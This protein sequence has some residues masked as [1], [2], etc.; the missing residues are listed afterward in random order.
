M[1]PPVLPLPLRPQDPSALK[2]LFP[3]VSTRTDIIIIDAGS[4]PVLE[5]WN[6]PDDFPTNAALD[7][8]FDDTFRWRAPLVEAAQG[9]S[10]AVEIFIRCQL[11]LVPFPPAWQTY[12]EALRDLRSQPF[13]PVFPVQPPVPAGV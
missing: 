5:V 6:I 9:I 11:S 7:A 4:G 13:P 3:D 12:Y 10:F 1:P 2:V 8:A